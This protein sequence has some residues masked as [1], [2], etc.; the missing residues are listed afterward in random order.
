MSTSI[1]ILT[2]NKIEYTKKCIESIRKFTDMTKCEVIIVDNNST[3]ETRDWLIKQKDLKVILNDENVGFPKG[4]NIGIKAAEKENDI[5]LLNNDTIV[6]YNWLTNLNECLN[7]DELIGAVGPVTN[8]SAYYQQIEVDYKDIEGI[9]EFGL[10]HNKSNKELWE[11]RQKLIGFCMLIK[12]KALDEVGLLDEIFTPGNFEDDDYSIRLI[13]KGYKLV[14]CRD[15]FIHHYGGASF[16]KNKD[17]SAIIAKN[18]KA[19]MRKWGFTSRWN[20][21]IYRNYLKLIN[22]RNPKILEAF[23]GTGATAL[24]ITQNYQCEYYGYENNKSALYYSRGAMEFINCSKDIKENSKFDYFIISDLKEFFHDTKLIQEMK[25]T[26]GIETRVIVNLRYNEDNEKKIAKIISYLGVEKYELTD[27]IREESTI[28]QNLNRT[29]IV[30]TDKRYQQIINRLKNINLANNLEEDFSY[31][32]KLAIDD[33]LILS[34]IINAILLYSNEISEVLNTFGVLLFENRVLNCGEVFKAAYDYNNE[35][36]TT[37]INNSELFF[38]LEQYD[39]ALIFIN[40]INQK[41]QQCLELYN[42]IIDK[43]NFEKRIKFIIRRIDFDIDNEK[44]AKK[45]IELLNNKQIDEN[46]IIRCIQMNI[47]NKNKVL[48]YLAIAA[49]ENQEYDIILPLL[50]EAY[51]I[52]N[53][54]I[55]TNYNMAYFLNQ[56]GQGKLALNYL[57]NLNSSNEDIKEL[58][59]TIKGAL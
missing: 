28:N 30:L 13:D 31:L 52:D 21:N 5:L 48:N 16:S 24:Y 23:C 2:F 12:R 42:K 51:N 14:L 26:I 7:S 32:V 47:I 58:I 8:S 36:Y 45:I 57:Q 1:V 46:L 44:N 34:S 50:N 37:L 27:G 22:G 20:M 53:T 38:E 49:Y 43:I 33:N 3:D 40:K 41:D 25:N 39:L 11:Q 29:I 17:Y 59:Y 6:T 10:N 56:F 19:F 35:D 9:Y 15:T 55:D 4:C 54:D 18:E